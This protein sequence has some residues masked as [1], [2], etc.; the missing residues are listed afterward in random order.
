M[1]N[2]DAMPEKKVPQEEETK[3]ETVESPDQKG[4]EELKEEFKFLNRL[5]LNGKLDGEEW[6][7]D[8]HFPRLKELEQKIKALESGAESISDVEKSELRE[9]RRKQIDSEEWTEDDME[10]IKNLTEKEDSR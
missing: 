10:R 7:R 5:Q 1:F 2:F 4:I 9:L 6:N 3:I 8:E